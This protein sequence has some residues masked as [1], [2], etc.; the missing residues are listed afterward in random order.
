MVCSFNAA[1]L[2]GLASLLTAVLGPPSISAQ[3]KRNTCDENISAIGH[4]DVS[5]HLNFFSPEKETALGKQLALEVDRSSR[6]VDDSVVTDYLNRIAQQVAKNSDAKFPITIRII[7]SDVINAFTLPGGYQYVNR[8]LILATDSEAELASVLAF[9]IAQTALRSSTGQSTKGELTQLL[10]IPAMLSVPSRWAGY[11][12][13]QGLNMAIPVTF[14]KFS[15]DGV[16]AAD[17]CAVQYLYKAGYDPEASPEL[18]ERTSAY[19][20]KAQNIPKA[21]NTHPP[22]V[23]R[24]NSMRDEIARLLPPRDSEI[25]SSFNFEAMKERLHT[26]QSAAASREKPTLRSIKASGR[27][28]DDVQLICEPHN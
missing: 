16:T 12:M 18:L 28:G 26:W 1:L 17:F 10:S 9:G 25:E 7:D 24:V 22:T 5:G 4:R 2:A 8:G 3:A 14:L 19:A 20:Q 21:F 13:F 15:R 27:L 23:E 6:L 11:F